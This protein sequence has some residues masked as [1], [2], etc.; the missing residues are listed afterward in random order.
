MTR[1][2][3][4]ADLWELVAEQVPE[5]EAIVCG[6]RRL[7]YAQA[8]ERANRLA[9]HLRANGVLAGDHVGV[10][11]TNGTEY[12]ETMLAAYKLRAV[13]INVNY[14]YVEDELAYLIDNADMEA[15]VFH[16][17][18]GDRVARVRARDRR[19]VDRD[20]RARHDEIDP[21]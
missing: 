4:F 8:D 5:R 6:E 16:S 11:L 15:L 7:T 18:L 3:A 21:L 14:R 20:S 1:S 12:L 10:Y 9:S 13:P 19:Y 17:S 2:F